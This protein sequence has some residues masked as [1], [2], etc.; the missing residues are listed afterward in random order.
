MCQQNSFVGTFAIFV[1][2]V[3]IDNL[4]HFTRKNKMET[5][6]RSE[7]RIY[8]NLETA[9]PLTALHEAVPAMPNEPYHTITLHS[10][11]I[12]IERQTPVYKAIAALEGLFLVASS[13]LMISLS[14]ATVVYAYT[15]LTS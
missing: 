12:I 2:T 10:H 15:M 5:T 6:L 14:G 8:R 7:K 4:M 11:R 3:V 1:Q 9:R 13:L